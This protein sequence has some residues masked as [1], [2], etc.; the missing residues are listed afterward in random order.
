MTDAPLSLA[1]QVRAQDHERYLLS[2]LQPAAVQPHLWALLAF[3]GEIARVPEVVSQEMVG[4]IRLAWWKER[5]AD[6]Y[7]GGQ[8]YQHEVVHGLHDWISTAPPPREW[9]EALIEARQ[10]QAGRTDIVSME[11]FEAFARGTAGQLAALMSFACCGDRGLA[12]RAVPIGTAYGM[13]G[14][15]R[16]APV[17]LAR[18]ELL[19]PDLSVAYGLS[20]EAL[21]EASRDVARQVRERA[22]PLLNDA[23]PDGI[24]PL[25]AWLAR[26]WEAR[27]RAAGDDMFSSKL[28]ESLPFLALR[29]MMVRI[30][31]KS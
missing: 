8:P 5:I 25:L 21:R 24:T 26:A 4:L 18:G 7:A 31:R 12:E 19:L 27:I 15:V 23:P 20:P 9:L 17:A 3:A 29:L 1:A 16:S 22:L 28:Q 30:L 13:L 10:E 6:V 11:A 14:L 2:L